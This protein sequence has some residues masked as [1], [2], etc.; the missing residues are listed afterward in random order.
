MFYFQLGQFNRANTD[1]QEKI[2]CICPP[3][4]GI[5]QRLTFVR[6]DYVSIM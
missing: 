1:G 2:L 3:E 5:E 4:T 6:Y